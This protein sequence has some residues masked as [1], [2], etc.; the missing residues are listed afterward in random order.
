VRDKLDRAQ[1]FAQTQFPDW[2]HERMLWSPVVPKGLADKLL[3]LETELTH[4]RSPVTIIVNGRFTERVEELK[5]VARMD[6]S[7]TDEPAFRML[8]IL[9]RLRRA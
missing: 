4:Q 2:T 1:Q 6:S 7:L 3:A 5:Q 9:E 8:Q